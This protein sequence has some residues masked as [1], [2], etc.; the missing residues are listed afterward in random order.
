MKKTLPDIRIAFM[1]LFYNAGSTCRAIEIAKFVRKE[2]ESRR[3]S[4]DDGVFTSV[5]IKFISNRI[6]ENA[7]YL[8]YVKDA[9][10]SVELC[11]PEFDQEMWAAFLEAERTGKGVFFPPPYQD[12][13]SKHIRGFMDALLA[14]RPTIVVHGLYPQASIAAKILKIPTCMYGPIPTGSRDWVN[15]IRA[16]AEDEKH[17]S[18]QTAT[19]ES[20]N[21]ASKESHMITAYNAAVECGWDPHP[22]MIPA[23]LRPDQMLVCDLKSNYSEEELKMFGDSTHMVG[24]VFAEWQS[25]LVPK[26]LWQRIRDVLSTDEPCKVFFTM[27]STGVE[28]YTLE[29]VKAICKNPGEF[30][31]VITI[32]PG[33]CSMDEVW[34]VIEKDTTRT[35]EDFE[36]TI[37]ITDQFV[38]FDKIAAMVDVVLMHG[39]QGSVQTGLA[40]GTPL[41]GVHMHFEQLFNLR[42]VCR[43]GAGCRLSQDDWTADSI[44]H[45][46]KKVLEDSSFRH[47]ARNI[48]AEMERID[49]RAEAA[50]LV[51]E[52]ANRYGASGN[53]E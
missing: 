5:D 21:P 43:R 11:D 41:V 19:R 9:G 36:Q 39:G 32:P 27:A 17:Q 26:E 15:K 50:R 46:L 6:P 44:H 22:S 52:F 12:Q 51:L 24:P 13:A 7:G 38:P 37:V 53:V 35:K 28:R 30:H 4:N 33:S 49:G 14:Y 31:A 20:G 29:A 34:R 47:A 40:A 42:N 18:T 45:S 16:M 3:D 1:A 10:F 8:K 25:T 23:L 2:L 48:Q